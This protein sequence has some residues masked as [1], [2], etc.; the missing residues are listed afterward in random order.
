MATK[1]K[2][3]HDVKM[4]IL[5]ER[6]KGVTGRELST[7]L[8]VSHAAIY[9]F[10][11]T[12]PDCSSYCRI[13]KP[14]L[15][16]DKVKTVFEIY[17]DGIE[18]SDISE[19]TGVP[20]DEIMQL[21]TYVKQPKRSKVAFYP[22]Y[23]ELSDWMAANGVSV[24]CLAEMLHVAKWQMLGTLTGSRYHMSIQMAKSISDITGL[25]VNVIYNDT[26]SAADVS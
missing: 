20:C 16:E 12:L 4:K 15:D 25:P 6:L 21:F 17:L 13:F 7:T 11:S 14:S 22:L 2:L 10:L 23:P 9:A 19:L 1:G 3:T 5:M 26:P 18:P 24:N 8:G